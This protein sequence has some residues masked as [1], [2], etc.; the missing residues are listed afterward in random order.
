MERVAPKI[1]DVFIRPSGV[2]YQLDDEGI[3]MRGEPASRL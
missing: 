1:G 3:G 2:V